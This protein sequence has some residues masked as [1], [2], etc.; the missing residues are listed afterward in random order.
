[1]PVEA[2]AHASVACGLVACR[3]VPGHLVLRCTVIRKAGISFVEKPAEEQFGCTWVWAQV[4][5]RTC[6]APWACKIHLCGSDPT[7]TKELKPQTLS[8]DVNDVDLYNEH[9]IVYTL[10]DFEFTKKMKMN[11]TK[12]CKLPNCLPGVVS[13]LKN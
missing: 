4:R 13:I 6:L 3:T 8:I 10:F 5:R 2:V 1:M 9:I 7:L 12:L 11:Q